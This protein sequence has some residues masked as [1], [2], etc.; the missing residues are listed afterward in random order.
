M[1]QGLLGKLIFFSHSKYSLPFEKPKY[2][3]QSSQELATGPYCESD[4]SRP[5]PPPKKT[6]SSKIHIEVSITNVKERAFKCKYL[7]S[8]KIYFQYI[9]EQISL[10]NYSGKNIS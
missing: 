8:F 10:F 9:W 2:L 6:S 4:E 3:L 5:P 1:D 7:K